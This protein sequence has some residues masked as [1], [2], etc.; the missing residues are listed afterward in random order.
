MVGGNKGYKAGDDNHTLITFPNFSPVIASLSLHFS[1][2]MILM[3]NN[4]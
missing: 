3:K 2:G 1:S 4:I